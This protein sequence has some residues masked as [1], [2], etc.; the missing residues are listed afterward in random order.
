MNWY[1]Y[2]D[3]EKRRQREREKQAREEKM[4]YT[5]KENNGIM[6]PA[7]SKAQPKYEKLQVKYGSIKEANAAIERFER[8]I[9]DLHHEQYMQLV[10]GSQAGADAMK[11]VIEMAT[12]QRDA[13]QQQRDAALGMGPGGWASQGKSVLPAAGAIPDAHK[14]VNTGAVAPKDQTKGYQ[15]G[16]NHAFGNVGAGVAA[17][18]ERRTEAANRGMLHA[19]GNIGAGIQAEQQRKA[20]AAEAANRGRNHIYSNVG[21]GVTLAQE[22]KEEAAN[23]GRNHLY[24]NMGEGVTRAQERKERWQN[25]GYALGMSTAEYDRG[26]ETLQNTD[27]LSSE[28]VAHESN[29]QAGLGFG[30][31]GTGGAWGGDENAIPP[32]RERK[33]KQGSGTGG[34]WGDV[35][36][37]ESLE[38]IDSSSMEDL[39]SLVPNGKEILNKVVR[40]TNTNPIVNPD[41][42]QLKDLSP[43]LNGVIVQCC[44]E[45]A[46]KHWSEFPFGGIARNIHDAIAWG[47]GVFG[48]W[49]FVGDTWWGDNEN[50]GHD[51]LIPDEIQG[52]ASDAQK[53][54]FVVNGIRMNREQFGNY[55]KGATA[56]KA[57]PGVSAAKIVS[58]L[59]FTHSIVVNA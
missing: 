6:K 24:T 22:R 48:E 23:R 26:E 16:M 4:F 57:F 51:S 28:T 17:E 18:Q 38:N 59:G 54:Y 3:E 37:E 46:P 44:S 58:M 21:E 43:E 32:K 10:E 15:Q 19:H 29:I 27:D 5:N 11:P 35:F 50:T 42:S 47:D 1:G 34:A 13:A 33:T 25:H 12:W 55:V 39:V 52:Y 9:D 45:Y 20:Q 14:Y 56:Q 7:Q 2:Q 53:D 31:G 36:V 49:D 30:G 40:S 41:S 8:Q